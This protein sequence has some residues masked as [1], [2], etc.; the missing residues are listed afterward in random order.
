MMKDWTDIIGEEL[1]SIQEPLPADDWIVLQQKHAASRRKKRI[2]AF[3]WVGSIASAAAMVVLALLLMY[4]EAPAVQNELVAEDI[5]PVDV[6]EE[7]AAV[8]KECASMDVETACSSPE[9]IL[10]AHKKP[11]AGASPK[12]VVT[13]EEAEETVGIIS[14]TTSVIE[15]LIAEVTPAG[16]ETEMAVSAWDLEELPEEKPEHRKIPMSFGVTGAVSEKFHPG[17]GAALGDATT[18]P[19]PFTPPDSLV[20]E[21]YILTKGGDDKN[22]GY[23]DSY[24]HEHPVSFGVSARFHLTKRFAVNTGLNYTKYTSTRERYFYKYGETVKDK[25]NVHYIGIPLRLDWMIVN[26]ARFNFYLGY[27]ISIDKC[28]YASVAGEKLREKEFIFSKIYTAGLQVNLTP[29][30]GIYFEPCLMYSATPGSL[31]T[32]RTKSDYM[33]SAR[34]GLRFN[35]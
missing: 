1:D 26:R 8:S 3:A 29:Q 28:I 21:M 5:S 7:E 32:L 17:F 20:Q 4:P 24:V 13:S 10:A 12:I 9:D 31:Q 19:D 18:S 22:G 2:A 11:S 23:R 35:F 16:E 30:A 33:I 25:Q 15:R 6:I 14:D 27:G 34:G